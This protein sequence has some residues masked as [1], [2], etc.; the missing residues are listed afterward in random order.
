VS[1]RTNRPKTKLQKKR[2]VSFGIKRTSHNDTQYDFNTDTYPD[3]D[4]DTDPDPYSLTDPDSNCRFDPYSD[5]VSGSDFEPDSDSFSI[6][7]F[8]FISAYTKPNCSKSK[9]KFE[10]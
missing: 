1:H 7:A 10:L 6:S 3:P 5:P 8:D 4:S 9:S 2:R